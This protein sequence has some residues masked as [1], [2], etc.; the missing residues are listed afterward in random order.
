[1]FVVTQKPSNETVILSFRNVYKRVIGRKIF[2]RFSQPWLPI[3]TLKA[4]RKNAS[5]NVVC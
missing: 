2:A 5:E 3:L 4:P 1:M